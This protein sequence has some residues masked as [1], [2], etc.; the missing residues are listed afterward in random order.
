MDVYE[1]RFKNQ[2]NTRLK[3]KGKLI[4]LPSLLWPGIP[5]FLLITRRGLRFVEIKGTEKKDKPFSKALF[6]KP[7]LTFIRKITGTFVVF[8]RNTHISFYFFDWDSKS[9]DYM[10]SVLPD[11]DHI[12]R[13]YKD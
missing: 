1:K 2:K 13:G 7:Q 12:V 4:K 9:E 6:T 10:I 11:F 8:Y 3:F 5:D